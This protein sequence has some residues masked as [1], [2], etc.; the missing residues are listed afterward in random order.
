MNN[1]VIVALC[2][3]LGSLVA[4]YFS[5]SKTMYRIEQ[6]EKKMEKHNNLI[7]RTYRLEQH[8]SVVDEQIK[9]A[10]HRIEDL[11]NGRN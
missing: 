11:E 5:S 4:G 6:L 1:A 9:V 3:L 7:E 2:S 10:N 8:Q